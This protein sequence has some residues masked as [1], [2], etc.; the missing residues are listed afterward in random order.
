MRA[1]LLL[2]VL[3]MIGCEAE[4]VISTHVDIEQMHKMLEQP[5]WTAEEWS[6]FCEQTSE[7]E[8]AQHCGMQVIIDC[9]P[10]CGVYALL[11]H[12]KFLRRIR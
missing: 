8:G 4:P 1:A 3:C 10:D 7:G 6:A 12:D 2:L 11:Q 9:P 5:H